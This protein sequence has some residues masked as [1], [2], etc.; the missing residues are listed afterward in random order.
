LQRRN[1]FTDFCQEIHN[2]E[3]FV[4]HDVRTLKDCAGTDGE[5]LQTVQSAVVS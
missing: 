3:L 2:V 5:D 1:T 4:Q